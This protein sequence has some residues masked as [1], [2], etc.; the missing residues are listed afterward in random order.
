MTCGLRDRAAQ[1]TQNLCRQCASV[2]AVIEHGDAFSSC[3]R[4]GGADGSHS[5][6]VL[7]SVGVHG[8]RIG[9]RA[10]AVGP[11]LRKL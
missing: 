11:H 5:T 4:I 6:L 9:Q 3:A 2:Q 8:R 10:A 1:V 7:F